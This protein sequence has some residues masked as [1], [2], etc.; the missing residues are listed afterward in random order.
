MG[1]LHAAAADAPLPSYDFR[2]IKQGFGW[3][4]AN[5]II[6]S[7]FTSEGLQFAITG[8]DPFLLSPA[9]NYPASA[10]LCLHLRLRSETGGRGQV[11]FFQKNY[12][13]ENSLWFHADK[14]AWTEVRLP[15]PQL[16]SGVK[17]RVD[18]PGGAGRCIISFIR[19][20]HTE[21]FGIT[22]VTASAKDIILNTKIEAP[23]Q[24][25][26]LPFHQSYAAAAASNAA[27]VLTVPASGSF[28]IPR[29]DGA[30]DRLYSI[31][32]ATRTNSLGQRETIGPIR[33]VEKT[34][35][36]SQY[37]LP[38]PAASSKKGLQVQMIDDALALGVKHA[39]LNLNLTALIDPTKQANNYFWKM[40]GETFH[41][42]R[43]YI[44]SLGIKQLTDAGVNVSLILLAYASGDPGRDFFLHPWFDRNAPNRLGAFNVRTPEGVKW[45]KA[46]MEFL[47]DRYSR[48]DAV[49]GH[50]WGYIVGN[51]V[52]SHW[53]WYNMGQAR[54]SLV[55]QEYE[56]AVRLIHTAIRKYSPS[57]RVYLS[58]EHHWNTAYERNLFRTCTGRGLVDEFNRL[59][60]MGGNFDW[61][62]AFHPYPEDLTNPRTWEDRTATA[63][64]NTAR[65][66]FRNLH[67]LPAYLRQSVLLYNG[68]PR[69]IIL[70]EQGFNSRGT[71]ES[72]L[73]QAA[74]YCYAYRKVDAIEG[75][76]SFIYHRH[77]D[78][79]QEGGLN[80]GLWRR[81]QNTISNPG[82]QKPIYRVFQNAD[83]DAWAETFDFARS[84][85]GINRWE[86]ILRD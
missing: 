7:S 66:T 49:N 56:R 85:I 38:Y 19:V 25:V 42:N 9:T 10:K 43:A 3:Q 13:E 55:A 41:F 24:I 61:H 29:F 37:A 22:E 14:G 47:A 33:F 80:L 82:S 31:F 11:F 28:Q 76:D 39:A 12:T 32:V 46:A 58:L 8:N 68:Q 69:R 57:A 75:I 59:A 34:G 83:T 20:E 65:I 86:E 73:E 72:E 1:I 60:Q 26:E 79:S 67:L 78:H 54:E 6:G 44:D 77:V 30:R 23:V 45:L 2:G 35:N 74:A 36:I 50:V 64:P 51:E 84:I 4:A 62:L 17:L 52:N 21:G 15:L 48:P 27:V 16:G 5:H 53:H 63:S 70:S 40:D 71:A 18:P 81:Q